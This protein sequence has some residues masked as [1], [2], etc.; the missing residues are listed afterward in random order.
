MG[1]R[2]KCIAMLLAGGQGSRLGALTKDIA[3]PAVSF[4]GKYRIIDFSLSNCANSGIDT[5]G[6]LT[7]YRPF[8]LNSY[9]GD[10]EAWDFSSVDGGVYILPPYETQTGGKWYKG[11]A[12]AIYRN[13]DFLRKFDADYVLILSGD[14][15]Y[16]MNYNDM[17]KDHM[18]KNAAATISVM[19]VPWDE[20]SRFGILSTDENNKVTKFAEKPKKPESNLASMGIYIF[21]K[22]LLIDK[23]IEDADDEESNHDFGKNIIP[24][25]LN[26]GEHVNA[27]RFEGYWKDVGTIDSYYE[28]NMQLLRE[29][30]EFSMIDEKFPIMSNSNIYPVQYIGNTATLENCIINNGCKIYGRIKNSIIGNGCVVKEGAYIEDSLVLP[31]TVIEEDVKIVR[32]II[33]ERTVVRQGARIGLREG[34][35]TVIGNN[36]TIKKGAV[37]P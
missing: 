8:E 13:L 7:Q 2:K 14:H 23:L 22:D 37:K 18:K 26:E 35:I 20:A 28:T 25:L 3:K 27:Y 16:R 32:S 4:G 21:T 6:V 34:E 11:T 1:R 17:L 15:L 5:V 19:E 31:D 36:E 24:K 12:D 9:V 10:G 30:P 29:N 33:G